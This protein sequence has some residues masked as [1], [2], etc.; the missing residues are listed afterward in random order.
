MSA[1]LTVLI[2]IVLVVF[3]EPVIRLFNDNPD[4]VRFG[5]ITLMVFIPP[6]FI[7][8]VYNS[9]AGVI[10]GAGRTVEAMC[11]S[12]GTMCILRL[13]MLGIINRMKGSFAVL[14]A[15]F[16]VT[17]VAALAAILIYMWR[18]DWM[19]TKTEKRL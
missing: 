3:R 16:P 14:L 5:V 15:I 8:A 11:I 17:W 13:A 12:I 19:G 7:F 10:T 18:A 2:S 4:V 6:Y 1:A 9:L